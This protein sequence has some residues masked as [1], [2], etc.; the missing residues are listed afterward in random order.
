MGR[1]TMMPTCQLLILSLLDNPSGQRLSYPGGHE[2]QA[3]CFP[4]FDTGIRGGLDVVRGGAKEF[5]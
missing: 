1:R 3:S 5:M 4:V 2:S